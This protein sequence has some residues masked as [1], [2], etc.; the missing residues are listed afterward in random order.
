MTILDLK[1]PCPACKGSGQQAG[2][3]DGGIS[4]IHASG[5]CLR[6]SGRGFLLTDLGEDVWNMLRPFIRDLIDERL[7]ARAGVGR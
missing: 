2:I 6:C 3:S 4:Q 7:D 1:T 5:R